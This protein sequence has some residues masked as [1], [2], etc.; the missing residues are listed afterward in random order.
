MLTYWGST[1]GVCYTQPFEVY[2]WQAYVPHGDGLWPTLGLHRIAVPSSA[3]SW[4]EIPATHFTAP[5]Y[6]SNMVSHAVF[7][8]WWRVT[9]ITS[10]SLH[11]G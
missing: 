8:A 3:S 2:P 5:S 6:S 10:P 11:G 9:L 4:G 1:I 7:G